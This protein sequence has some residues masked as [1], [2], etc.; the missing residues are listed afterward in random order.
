[1][2]RNIEYPNTARVKVQS[3]IIPRN[4]FTLLQAKKWL[5]AHNFK[6]NK[7]DIT[8]NFYRFRQ[9]NPNKT[10]TYFVINLDGVKLIMTR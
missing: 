9:R 4:D 3:V 7:I 8:E 5:N 1:M 10:K 6:L 2:E